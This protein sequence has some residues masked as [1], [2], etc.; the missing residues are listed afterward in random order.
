MK[1]VV[2]GGS[3]LIG[4]KL[5]THLSDAGH[6]AVPASLE[7]G[8]NL[9]TGDGL[10]DAVAGAA[11][12]VDV[13][14]SPSFAD[15]DVMAFFTTS[16]RNQL[17]AERAAGVGHHVA[18]SVV[19]ADL[20]PDSGYLRAKVAQE[21]AIAAGGVPYTILRSSQFFEFVRR[22]ADEATTDGT[23]RLPHALMQPVAA[24]DVALALAAIAQDSPRNAIVE[25]GGPQSF[26][27]DD[28]AR[29]VLRAGGDPRAVLTDPHAR[30]FGA[31]LDDGALRP[32]PGARI[33]RIRLADWLARNVPAH[34]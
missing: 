11:V 5:V 27:L 17:A 12:I 13:S 22:I 29:D 24:D 21:Q 33:G 26:P 25:L 10:A 18:L 8:V 28:L 20:L 31:E 4:S 19:G 34:A 7:T 15:D 6:E 1:I 16:T 9:L 3:G 30:Y 32:G 2:I 14:N 23:V